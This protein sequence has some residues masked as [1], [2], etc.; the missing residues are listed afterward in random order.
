M[1]LVCFTVIA[2]TSIGY[3]KQHL[4]VIQIALIN[5]VSPLASSKFG[6]APQSKSLLIIQMFS[7]DIANDNGV[8]PCLKLRIHK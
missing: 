4:P 1:G 3:W 7:F 8:Q 6:S 2:D 5:G